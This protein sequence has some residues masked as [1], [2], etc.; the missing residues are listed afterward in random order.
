MLPRTTHSPAW[1]R[2]CASCNASC[3][4][5]VNNAGASASP[6]SQPC[7]TSCRCP[8]AS[9]AMALFQ[10]RLAQRWSALLAFDAARAFGSWLR[11]HCTGTARTGGKRPSKT[12]KPCGRRYRKC[13]GHPTKRPWHRHPALSNLCRHALAVRTG[14]GELSGQTLARTGGL[15]QAA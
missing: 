1:R 13:I 12:R 5:K 9:M 7:G 2:P 3:G 15:T 6:C 11:R 10:A 14:V 8:S 4:A